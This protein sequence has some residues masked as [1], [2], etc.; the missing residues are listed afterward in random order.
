LLDSS[1]RNSVSNKAP[2]QSQTT[3]LLP[4]N[5]IVRR[6]PL[7]EPKHPR[8]RW[9]WALLAL[10]LAIL[11]FVKDFAVELLA[12]ALQPF[13]E[14]HRTTVLI[15][16]ALGFLAAL[17]A[18]LWEFI[19]PAE[20]P[21][22]EK[23]A[24]LNQG[25][26][27][28]G[29]S[30]T[31]SAIATGNHNQINQV[32]GGDVVGTKIVIQTGETVPRGP[33]HQLPTPPAHFTGREAELERLL[34]LLE[35]GGALIAGVRGMGG[36]GKSA[37]A[38]VL[39]WRVK[40]RYPAAQLFLDLGGASERPLGVAEALRYFILAFQPAAKLPDDEAQL[41]ALYRSHLE[42]QRALIVLDNA[43]AGVALD[44]LRPPPGCALLVTSRFTV[45][46]SGLQTVALDELPPDKAQAYLLKVTPRIGTHAAELAQ[47]CG[48]LPLALELAAGALQVRDELEPAD[49]ARRLRDERQRWKELGA[50]EAALALS[51]GLLDPVARERWRALAVFPR[52]FD[53]RAAAAVW[54]MTDE[55]ADADAALDA[56]GAL[57]DYSLLNYDKT[58]RRWR[59]HDLARHYAAGRLS[60]AERQQ[61]SQ[62]HAAHY[63]DVL[64]QAD[65][66]YLQ[67]GAAVAQG[68]SLFDQERENVLA[69]QAWVAAQGNGQETEA[70]THLCMEYPYVGAYVLQLRLHPR[71]QI[72]WLETQCAAARSLG[73]RD[74]EGA[75][76]GNLGRAY[77]D[78][79][80][81]R[82]AIAYYEQ[83]LVI[84]R[85]I[86]D[87]RGEGN[88]LGNLGNAYADLG[89]VRQAI[90]YHEQALVIVREIG[91]RRGEGNALGNL[92]N[93]YF[94]LGE[95]RQAIAYYEQILIIHREIGDRRGE[96]TDLGNLGVAYYNLGEVRQ[97]IA[98]Y[99]QQLVIAREIGDRRGEGNALGNLGSA[100]A[101]LGEVRQAIAYYEQRLVIA[102]EI[103]DRRGEGNALGNLGTA[104]AD[105]GEVRQAIAYYEQRLVIAREI[106]D[107]R[108]EGNALW[109]LS[110]SLDM[111][112]E[113]AQAIAHA[114][115][116]LQ[117]YEA[118]ESP[119]AE[120][121]RRKLAEWR[122]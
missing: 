94:A 78:L 100:Y 104:Y 7:T 18:A 102:R 22:E 81:V 25:N 64:G 80:E 107:R 52:S 43:P 59:L 120:K 84:A 45:R 122:G 118:I 33:L 114:E 13:V 5:L 21:D 101:D 111:L 89:E 4:R 103:G 108:G 47:L 79:G 8:S 62:R 86:G 83:R 106:G 6:H 73:R 40:D 36:V 61:Y 49:Y 65:E 66:L 82:Q 57:R 72:R 56:L 11:L 41:T 28:L 85:E 2:F 93:A 39:G 10:L 112:G 63:C 67:G 37:L 75:A 115:A 117:L 30:A 121:V 38:A 1:A 99:E 31:R 55:D 91:D 14:K 113:R 119:A 71:E 46:L 15:T 44:A 34:P 3:D 50:V 19:K 105:L 90:A 35:T 110:L 53:T 95:V 23:A 109:N 48:H 96:G 20:A 54:D 77:A 29:G 97:A 74:M 24:T 58:E 69:G 51:Y 87:R 76:L 32:E 68:L 9:P 88:A 98:Y 16:L 116:A 42:G 27:H 12:P 92:G 70:A 17:V 60:A 26:V